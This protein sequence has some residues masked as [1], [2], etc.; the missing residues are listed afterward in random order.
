MCVCL[1]VC[2]CAHHVTGRLPIIGVGGVRS[3]QDAYEK[4][5]AGASLI[6]IYTSLAIEGPP[7]IARIKA[8]LTEILR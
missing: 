3:G 8:E 6:Q 4:L 5:R 1:F 2:V 7:V